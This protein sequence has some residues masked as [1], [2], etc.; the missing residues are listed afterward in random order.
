MKFVN[1]RR[2]EKFRHLLN[3]PFGQREAALNQP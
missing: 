2:R 3:W 1:A